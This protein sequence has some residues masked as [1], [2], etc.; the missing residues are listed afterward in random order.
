M[1]QPEKVGTVS[2]SSDT[3]TTHVTGAILSAQLYTLFSSIVIFRF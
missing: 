1:R 2:P 3:G